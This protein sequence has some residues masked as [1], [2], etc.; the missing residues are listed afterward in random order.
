MPARKTTT[1]FLL[2]HISKHVSLT[3][4]EETF[5]ISMM[6][7]KS[8]KAG[9]FLF[10]VGDVCKYESFVAKGCLES[11]YEDEHGVHRVLDFL[12]EEWW[13]DDLYSFLTQSPST[14]N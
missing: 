4:D 12:V 7:E 10:R 14:T 1:E 13:A 9:D 2:A 5:F 3:R 11:Y 6:E 8:L